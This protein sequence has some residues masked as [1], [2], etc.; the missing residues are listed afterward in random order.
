MPRVSVIV[1]THERFHLLP[2]AL[3]SIGDQ[4]YTDFEVLLVNDGGTFP[5]DFDLSRYTYPLTVYH[6]ARGG[7]GSAR[8]LGIARASGELI[9][10]LDDDDEWSP[11]HL[12]VLVNVIDGDAAVAYS[13]ARVVERG[14]T[15]RMWGN[16]V[17]S[18]F[19]ADGFYT[20]FP[21]SAMMHRHALVTEAGLF[22]EHQLL[23]GPE[24]CEFI[25]RLSDHCKPVPSL[26]ETVTMHR[27]ESFTRNPRHEWV[28]ALG[29]VMKKN[30]YYDTRSNWL[31]YYRAFVAA[32][33][34]SRVVE[35]ALWEE[36][37]LNSL[38]AG[39][40]LHGVSILGRHA[41]R[42]DSIKHFCRA[43]LAG[44]VAVA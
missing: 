38:P 7:P 34:E 12:S 39:C 30:G 19:V 4:G 32:V 9:A 29:Y 28:D 20:I 6:K 18:K 11:Q 22:D 13:C 3:A 40:S 10:Y 36:L 31:M 37:L 17:F 26:R 8:N 44:R 21:P 27:E 1:T 15:L 14:E 16:S 2:R 41:L 43:I 25:L 33:A 24:D 42:P 35:K 5:A 23:V